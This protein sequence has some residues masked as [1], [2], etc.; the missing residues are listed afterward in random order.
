MRLEGISDMYDEI[1][2]ILRIKTFVALCDVFTTIMCIMS[3]QLPNAHLPK[4]AWDSE[5]LY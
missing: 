3:S 2:D 4:P 5:V 1:C